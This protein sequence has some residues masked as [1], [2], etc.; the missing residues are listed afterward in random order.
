MLP[1][2]S[3]ANEITAK[4]QFAGSRILV[5]EDCKDLQLLTTLI[6]ED[7][8]AVVATADNGLEGLEIAEQSEFDLI[9]MDLRMPVM[10]GYTAIRNLRN[11]GCRIP[12]IAMT[13]SS[14]Q[15][16]LEKCLR[17]GFSDCICKPAPR[18]QFIDYIKCYLT[19]ETARH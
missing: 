3:E 12:V 16:E 8:G 6:L 5:V 1:D 19:K 17:Y 15:N 13:A 14:R 4:A 18:S 7:L 10:D 11:N 2:T 9:L